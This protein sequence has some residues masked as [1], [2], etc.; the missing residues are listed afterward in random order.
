M[1]APLSASF[2]TDS[3]RLSAKFIRSDD[4]Q[5]TQSGGLIQVGRPRAGLARA[6]PARSLR[7]V[8]R[9]L[10]RC[11][12]VLE[13]A[14]DDVGGPFHVNTKILSLG[15]TEI[16]KHEGCGI[17]ASILL[18]RADGQPGIRDPPMTALCRAEHGDRT[19]EP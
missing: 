19:L 16:L 12:A 17:H 11:Q 3:V 15:C 10:G 8:I 18:G 9:V 1:N 2:R 5:S 6:C 13:Q 7:G 4:Q 14:L